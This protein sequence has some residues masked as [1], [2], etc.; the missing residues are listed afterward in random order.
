M[1]ETT[2]ARK[3]RLEGERVAGDA[4]AE[5][6]DLH[7]RREVHDHNATMIGWG[8]VCGWG[9]EGGYALP[10]HEAH[11]AALIAPL[12]DQARAEGAAEAE[13]ALS[14]R[15]ELEV[16]VMQVR[17]SADAWW[18]KFEQAQADLDQLMAAVRTLADDWE[19]RA[20]AFD[21]TPTGDVY[22]ITARRLRALRLSSETYPTVTEDHPLQERVVAL[23]GQW[24]RDLESGA[25]DAEGEDFVRGSEAGL[26]CLRAVLADAD[27]EAV[28]RG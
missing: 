8:C 9:A 4:V 21:G 11:V 24:Q 20:E 6:L 15:D 13:A 1:T 22:A 10:D 27:N 17:A 7:H 16:K 2:D 23:V 3:R 26:D 5:V 18:G 28:D 25:Y 14:D 19:Q 12:L